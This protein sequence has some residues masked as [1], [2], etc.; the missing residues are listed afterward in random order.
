[1]IRDWE[2][3]IYKNLPWLY[4]LLFLLFY[5]A[6][7]LTF[8]TIFHYFNFIFED[9]HSRFTRLLHHVI[10]SSTSAVPASL[11]N[12]KM[13]TLIFIQLFAALYN[14]IGNIHDNAIYTSARNALCTFL[15]L[16]NS[17]SENKPNITPPTPGHTPGF[18]RHR[19]STNNKSIS[20]AKPSTTPNYRK[21]H[22]KSAYRASPLPP[23]L[24]IPGGGYQCAVM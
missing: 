12:S 23:L 3:K 14:Y 7:K 9:I 15:P 19:S 18:G 5:K 16:E 10:I 24:E 20:L 11:Y 1:M 6:T 17:A 2:R 8:E 4:L 21:H 22:T 13:L